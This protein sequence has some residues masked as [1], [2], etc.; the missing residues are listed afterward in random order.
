M[1]EKKPKSPTIE[2]NG[3]KYLRIPIKTHIIT[4]QD[5]LAEV[6]A[7][8]T[9]S[10]FQPGDIIVMSESVVAISQGRAIPVEQIHPGLVARFLWRFVRKVSYGIGLR[11]PESMQC[12][13]DEVGRFR[14]LFAAFIGMLGKLVGRRGDFYRIAGM[15]V[16]T[17]DAAYTTPIEPYHHCV[18]KGPKDPDK[19][20]MNV[21]E[22]TGV[23]TAIV[24]VNDIGGSWVLGASVGVNKPLVERIMKD[25]PLGQSDEQTPIGIIRLVPKECG[26][27]NVDCGIK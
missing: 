7:K 3:K 1:S 26:L 16:A 5:D 8:Y 2:I 9:S 21:K 17:I 12:A 18:I 15:Q 20:C 24:D 23:D 6:V 27:Q 22:K 19:V 10:Q 25:N 11:S 4:D 13:V 14:I